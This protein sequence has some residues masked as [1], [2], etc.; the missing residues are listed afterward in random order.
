MK[1]R[2]TI[3]Y[4]KLVSKTMYR[5]YAQC[6][7]RIELKENENIFDACSR[8]NLNIDTAVFIFEGWPR[9]EGETEMIKESEPL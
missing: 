8:I 1:N 6:M 7:A 9:L 2:F 5:V 3:I 4:N